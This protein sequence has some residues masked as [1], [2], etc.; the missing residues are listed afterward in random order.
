MFVVLT[1]T[2]GAI[3]TLIWNNT[4]LTQKEL[5]LQGVVWGFFGNEIPNLEWFIKLLISP[6]HTIFILGNTVI[7]AFRKTLFTTIMV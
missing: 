4:L 7:V 5:F 3:Y 2:D 6:D 1:P